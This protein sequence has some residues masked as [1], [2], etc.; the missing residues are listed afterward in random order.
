MIARYGR[1]GLTIA[2]C[3]R[4]D[5]RQSPTGLYLYNDEGRSEIPL[6]TGY[7]WEGLQEICAAVRENRNTFPDAY[8][9]RATLEVILAIMESGREGREVQ[10]KYQVPCPY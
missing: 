10:L 1:A 9:G 3:E 5:L 6:D 7:E 8:W 2:S 4:G